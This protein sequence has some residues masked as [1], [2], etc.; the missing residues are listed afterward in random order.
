MIERW[1]IIPQAPDYAVSDHGRVRRETPGR[2]TAPGRIIKPAVT[3]KGYLR[4]ALNGRCYFVQR[5][6]AQAFLPP[7]PSERH[8]IAHEDGVPTNNVWTN[9]AWKTPGENNWDRVRHGT[10]PRGE[11]H[12]MAKL[13]LNEV[14]QIRR[15]AS[16]GCFS[17]REIDRRP[18]RSSRRNHLAH[19]T[20]KILETHPMN[21]QVPSTALAT[22]ASAPVPLRAG[23]TVQPF[24]P[25]TY[26]EAWR[27]SKGIVEGGF[28]PPSLKSAE[29]VMQAI[30]YG[31]EVGMKPFM[32]LKNIAV[33]NGRPAV[34]GDAIPGLVYASGLCEFI[35]LKYEGEGDN[36]TAICTTKRKGAPG[37]VSDRFSVADAKKAGV[38][39][40]SGPWSAYPRRMLGVRARSFVLRDTYPD[41]LGGIN[42][43]EEIQDA[44]YIDVTPTPPSPDE[45]GPEPTS[46]APADPAPTIARTRRAKKTAPVVVE[47]APA[48]PEEPDPDAP[49]EQPEPTPEPEPE[50]EDANYDEA[51]TPEEVMAAFSEALQVATDK[52][53]IGE[54][55]DTF[56]RQIRGHGPVFTARCSELYKARIEE[57]QGETQEQRKARLRP[58]YEAGIAA[59]YRGRKKSLPERDFA[60]GEYRAAWVKGWENAEAGKEPNPNAAVAP[61]P[62]DF[63]GD[64]PPAKTPVTESAIDAA[65]ELGR[66]ARIK[67]MSQRALPGEYRSEDRA[68][69]A[70]A[71]KD[72]WQ[73]AGAE[74]NP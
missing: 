14:Q 22:T 35:E 26:E 2:L 54:V 62:D 18:L 9:L 71:W 59:F 13:G 66:Q 29:S 46:E 21:A 42:V 74:A 57:V 52:V 33:I 16:L 43:V 20:Q 11:K 60:E 23:G 8:T 12:G 49:E 51:R 73:D 17:Y 72:G 38:W 58:A 30:I 61:P 47:A 3:V 34:Y 53:S 44:D 48:P 1:A 5:L 6:V 41:I 27:M 31:L 70:A 39:G 32:A 63:P 69:E 28:N 55:W 68:A 15:L 50:I 19:R 36:L 10:M 56:D 7:R 64:S 4:V 37:P 45:D 24:I 40:K 25:T 65:Y 67:G